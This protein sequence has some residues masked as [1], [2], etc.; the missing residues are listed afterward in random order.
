[1]GL[2][3][4]A[5][6]NIMDNKLESFKHQLKHV[7]LLVRVFMITNRMTRLKGYMV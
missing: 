4:N 5:V 2:A 7:E 3:Q 1:M 6:E